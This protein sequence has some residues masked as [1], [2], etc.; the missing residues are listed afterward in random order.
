M[1]EKKDNRPF[2]E[3]HPKLN[4]LLGLFMLAGL[5]YLLY[6]ILAYFVEKLGVLFGRLSAM[7][8][9]LDAVIVVA[10]ITGTVSIVSVVFSSIISKIIEYKQ[11]RREYL[12][13]KR[14]EP[15]AEFVEVVY[16]L[17]DKTKRKE[18]YPEEEMTADINRFS[19]K[20][21]L[22]G[23][24]RVIKKWLKF[25]E[26]TTGK[27]PDAASTLFVMEDILFAMRKDLGLRKMKRGNLL[28][29]F[30][31]DIDSLTNH[32]QR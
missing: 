7:T 17:L 31:N 5:G 30:I 6:A 14:E 26:T 32:T 12:Y 23:S 1:T 27:Q 15:Y 28:S 19:K 11:K 25:R 22:W 8:S 10:L 2:S 24:N 29:F 9:N 16:K 13:Q 4:S 3:K 18:E 21:T 20:L